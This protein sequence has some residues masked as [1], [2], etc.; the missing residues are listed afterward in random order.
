MGYVGL[1]LA[2]GLSSSYKIIGFDIS[3][4]RVSQLSKGIDSTLEISKDKLI[5]SLN[6]KLIITCDPEKLHDCNI[7]IAT[8]PTPITKDKKPDLKPLINVCKI[9]AKFLKKGDIVILKVLFF[10]EQLKKF[11]HLNLKRI[12]KD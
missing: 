8:V 12:K 9:I 11:A 6:N 1:P 4:N 3:L 7:F 10:L 2:V 5:N